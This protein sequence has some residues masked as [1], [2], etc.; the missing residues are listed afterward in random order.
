MKNV[1]I[2]DD[3]KEIAELLSVYLMTD[4]FN[5]LTAETVDEAEKIIQSNNIDIALYN[6]III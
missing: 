1:L 6:G 4:G 5:V 3:E 2:V